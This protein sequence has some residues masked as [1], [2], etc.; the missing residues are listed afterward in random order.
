MKE[1][2][3]LG[4]GCKTCGKPLFTATPNNHNPKYY[5]DGECRY[6][7]WKAGKQAELMEL[8]HQLAGRVSL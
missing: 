1:L 5:C 7:G 6:K 2:V 3:S 4:R 8:I